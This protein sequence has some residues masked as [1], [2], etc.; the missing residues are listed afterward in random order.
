MLKSA[1]AVAAPVPLRLAVCVPMV[2]TTVSV[3]V[4][5]PVAD[6]LKD[7]PMEHDAPA[8]SVEPHVLLPITNID[9]FV[10]VVLIELMGRAALPLFFKVNVCGVLVAPTFTLPKETLV[11][12]RS[13]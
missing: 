2:S 6:G 10:P 4:A 1:A 7:T 12:D 5:F 9:A 8:S 3:A 11:G 13:A